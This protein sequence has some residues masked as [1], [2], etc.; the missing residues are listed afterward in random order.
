MISD[1]KHFSG[2]KELKNVSLIDS[3][4]ND[5]TEKGQ[6]G[7]LL[8]RGRTVCHNRDEKIFDFFDADFYCRQMNF[9]QA[10]KWTT[11]ESFDIQKNYPTEYYYYY[12]YLH[13]RSVRF[14]THSQDV[15]LSCTGNSFVKISFSF[16]FSL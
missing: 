7:L 14:C 16:P 2:D 1:D 15:F 12:Y 3:E 8:Y 13:Y 6:L 11:E 9:T 5:V 4:G 10:L